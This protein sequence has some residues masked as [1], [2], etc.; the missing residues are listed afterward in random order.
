MEEDRKRN[1][2]RG[3]SDVVKDIFAWHDKSLFLV[4]LCF[5]ERETAALLQ[6]KADFVGENGGLKEETLAK[7]R[8][9]SKV[10]RHFKYPNV[11]MDRIFLL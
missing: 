8:E 11:N 5:A 9:F 6:S 1:K 7:P 10:Y 2:G 3:C 4:S